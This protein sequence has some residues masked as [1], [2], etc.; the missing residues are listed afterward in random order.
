MV[1]AAQVRADCPPRRLLEFL[2]SEAGS[3]VDAAA[4][5]ARALP[6]AHRHICALPLSPP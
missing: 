5:Q 3:A 1:L 4:E 2:C 6:C